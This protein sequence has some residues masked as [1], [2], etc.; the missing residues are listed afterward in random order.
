MGGGTARERLEPLPRHRRQR[1][2]V[3]QAVSQN[4]RSGV[5]RAGARVRDDGDR[6][7]S[8]SAR[9]VWARPLFALDGRHWSRDLSAGLP[10]GRAVLPNDRCV[11][12]FDK[13]FAIARRRTA[14]LALEGAI[15]G[16]LR[17]VADLGR[18]LLDRLAGRFQ[19]TRGKL[20]TPA[21]QIG[22]RRIAQIARESLRKDRARRAGLG[23]QGFE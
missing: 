4:A 22:E 1:L 18:N 15:E 9:A 3:S 11:L 20:Q 16:R 6:A 5:A 10:E 2:R 14:E 8:R 23:G 7:I 17:I 19:Q 13:L 12:V 21:R